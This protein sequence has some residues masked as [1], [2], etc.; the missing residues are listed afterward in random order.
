M[1]GG[2]DLLGV[3]DAEFAA[4]LTSAPVCWHTVESK[5]WL[6]TKEIQIDIQPHIVVFFVFL[7]IRNK[8]SCQHRPLFM[9]VYVQNKRSKNEILS[10]LCDM[11]ATSQTVAPWPWT[12]VMMMMMM[13][14]E[15][16]HNLTK[17][18][19]NGKKLTIIKYKY[20]NSPFSKSKQTSML[21]KLNILV[22][23]S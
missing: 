18:K 3:I 11:N 12:T 20:Y 15:Q 23:E 8:Q 14:Q 16:L 2:A 7:N 9:C 4:T 22:L 17:K 6:Y 10:Y 19:E 5:N 13:R 21:A 1:V